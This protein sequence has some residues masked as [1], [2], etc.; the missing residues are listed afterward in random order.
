MCLDKLKQNFAMEEE[1]V[2]KRG[3][4]QDFTAIGLWYNIVAF[5]A[6]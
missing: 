4:N 6:T 1:M 3:R 5:L 2:V